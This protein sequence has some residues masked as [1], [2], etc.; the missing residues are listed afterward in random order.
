MRALIVDLKAEMKEKDDTYCRQLSEAKGDLLSAQAEL[1]DSRVKGDSLKSKCDR[2]TQSRNDLQAHLKRKVDELQVKIREADDSFA[3]SQ[4][5]EI[6]LR[7]QL[8]ASI[9]ANTTERASFE[10]CYSKVQLAYAEA[11]ETVN[12]Q[13]EEILL[14][15]R[16]IALLEKQIDSQAQLAPPNDS[17]CA[18]DPPKEVPKTTEKSRWGDDSSENEEAFPLDLVQDTLPPSSRPIKLHSKPS[19]K[20]PTDQMIEALQRRVEA[21]TLE[22]EALLSK[23][24]KIEKVELE[25]EGARKLRLANEAESKRIA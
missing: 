13:M 22:Q 5:T 14:S 25:K 16:R 9:T 18:I 17:S 8:Q 24:E 3:I 15:Q 1:E 11:K 10:L 12:M 2:L 20:I 7:A 4:G 21:A 19:K 6:S 23:T